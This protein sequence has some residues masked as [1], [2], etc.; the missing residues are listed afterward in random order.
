MT[1]RLSLAMI[2]KNEAATLGRCLASV[3]DL[4][5]EIIVV[6]TGSS[7]NTKDIARR[8]GAC[9]FDLPWPDSFAAARNVRYP[10]DT[11]L[12]FLKELLKGQLCHQRGDYAAARRCWTRLLEGQSPTIA[13]SAADGV[14]RSV[15]TG[16]RGPLA[17]QHL[18]WMDYDEGRF[19][20]AENHW[21][22]ML[23]ELPSC[24]PAR[25][26]LAELYLLQKRW[27]ELINLLSELEPHALQQAASFRARMNQGRQ[28]FVAALPEPVAGEQVERLNGPRD[29]DLTFTMIVDAG[30]SEGSLLVR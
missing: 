16:V 12:L 18:A 5:D 30:A 25:L 20:D 6:D 9:V 2:V 26:G 7:D 14:F 4:V 19:A 11:E 24:T 8:H 3:R 29:A 22:T 17:R 27:A 13:A 28:E 1:A 21:R 15:D 10:H 23:A